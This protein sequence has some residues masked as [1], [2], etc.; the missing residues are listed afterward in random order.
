MSAT[1]KTAVTVAIF[2]SAL[3][4]V[5]SLVVVI[6]LFNEINSMYDET[7]YDLDEFKVGFFVCF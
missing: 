7:M 2:G 6:G 5:V 3:A 4:T 1:V